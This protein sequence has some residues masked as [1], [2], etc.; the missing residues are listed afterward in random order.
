M[1]AIKELRAR[2]QVTQEELAVKIGVSSST[3]HRNERRLAAGP[4]LAPFFAVAVSTG[5][6][7]LALI[8]RDAMLA[9]IPEEDRKLLIESSRKSPYGSTSKGSLTSKA[10][11]DPPHAAAYANLEKILE[12]GEP[13]ASVITDVLKLCTEKIE[14]VPKAREKMT[15]RGM[16]ARQAAQKGERVS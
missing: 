10:A 3:V 14:A 2:M 4:A 1:N 6:E 16:R 13:D 9:T 5:N 12:H 8:L 11:T 7:D 15:S